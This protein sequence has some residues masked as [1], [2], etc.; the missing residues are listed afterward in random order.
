VYLL[1]HHFYGFHTIADFS[2]KIT[3]FPQTL[4]PLYLGTVRPG[5]RASRAYKNLVGC[6]KHVSASVVAMEPWRV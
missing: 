4:C 5:M 2:E 6:L 3:A 1:W